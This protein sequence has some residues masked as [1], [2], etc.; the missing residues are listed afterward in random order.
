MFQPIKREDI[1]SAKLFEAAK[2][3]D[4][5][6]VYSKPSK[7]KFKQLVIRKISNSHIETTTSQKLDLYS[8][9]CGLFMENAPNWHGFMANIRHVKHLPVKVKYHPNIPLDSS[10]YDAIYSTMSFV[11]QQI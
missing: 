11:K 2:F 9:F 3:N 10:S 7:S 6:K 8:I 4:N 5:I 1:F